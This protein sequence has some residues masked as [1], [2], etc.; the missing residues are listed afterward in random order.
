MPQTGQEKLDRL[1]AFEEAGTISD[2]GQAALNSLREDFP[3]EIPAKPLRSLEPSVG[4]FGGIREAVIPTM[5][6]LK[7]IP[8]GFR[9]IGKIGIGESAKMFGGALLEGQLAQFRKA[10]EILKQ[11]GGTNIGGFEALG[12]IGAGLVP[13]LGPF[14]A[15]IGE[16][17]GRGEDARAAGNIIGLVSPFALGKAAGKLKGLKADSPI[18]LLPSE[19]T[20]STVSG[21]IESTLEKNIAAAGTFRKFRAK[22]DIALVDELA[23]GVIQKL[24]R[25]EK[26][27]S[28]E[29]IGQQALKATDLAKEQFREISSIKF[30]EIDVI[31]GTKTVRRPITTQEVSRL[32]SPS[33]EPLT[34][35]KRTLKKQQVGGIQPETKSLKQFAIKALRRLKEEKKLIDPGELGRSE[36]L[37]VGIVRAPKRTSFQAFQDTRSDLLAITRS[38][39]DPIPGKVGG[40]AKK[41]SA[42]TDNALI[43]A[44]EKSGNP[45]IVSMVRE[46]NEFYKTGIINFNETVIS[47][48]VKTAPERIPA[49]LRGATIDDIR[50]MKSVLGEKAFRDVNARFLRETLNESISGELSA[51]LFPD[52]IAEKAGLRPELVPRL[53]IKKFKTKLEAQKSGKMSELFSEPGQAKALKEFLDEASKIRTSPQAG[54]IPSM[55]NAILLFKGI[56]GL[57]AFAEG[58]LL[59]TV[60]PIMLFAATNM[61]ARLLTSTKGIEAMTKATAAAAGTAEHIFWTQRMVDISR[62]I[63]RGQLGPNEPARTR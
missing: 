60:E 6:E 31:A 45:K 8:S 50:A 61:A 57:T 26:G 62:Q 7:G 1:L 51:Q 55:L 35:A 15:E 23:E 34:F 40:I 25:V 44:A 43:T 42:L 13:I 22:Q 12:R 29:E 28:S 56:E 10:G 24:S 54:F 30:A 2:Q 32:V 36:R 21:F 46:A 47:R 53:N 11:E 49:L 18:P 3:D 37:L 4:F 58:N 27:M 41:L 63:E 17:F 38:I 14:A 52:A 33:G 5:E 16:R 39:G 19:R 9:T 48:L 59:G 20:G